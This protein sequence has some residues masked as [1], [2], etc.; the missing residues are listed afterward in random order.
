M[1]ITS[2]PTTPTTPTV[3]HHMAPPTRHSCSRVRTHPPRPAAARLAGR[4]WRRAPLAGCRSAAAACLC[5][6][7][8]AVP[9]AWRARAGGSGRVRVGPVPCVRGCSHRA[10][11]RRSPVAISRGAWCPVVCRDRASCRARAVEGAGRARG[12]VNVACGS[13]T[14]ATGMGWVRRALPR[15]PGIAAG[16]A[17]VAC[18]ARACVRVR[19]CAVQCR[20]ARAG[21]SCAGRP[22]GG[23]P[24]RLVAG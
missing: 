14:S 18:R 23:T 21:G 2:I 6:L 5:A 19:A 17:P 10:W 16:A 7:V 4:A 8:A 3:P 24:L 15:A 9:A 13:R 22:G 20:A 11:M 12:P 1:A